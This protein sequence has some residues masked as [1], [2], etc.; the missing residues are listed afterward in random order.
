MCVC[1]RRVKEPAARHRVVSSK[2]NTSHKVSAALAPARMMLVCP[3]L[4]LG[5]YCKHDLLFLEAWQLLSPLRVNSFTGY[6]TQL[7]AETGQG[8][9]QVTGKET[10]RCREGD[11]KVRVWKVSGCGEDLEV[12]FPLG[13]ILVIK[14]RLLSYEALMNSLAK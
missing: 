10:G 6:S 5:R 3:A 11:Q 9:C 8:S 14:E 1:I 12:Q 7:P 4:L 13:S 2:V